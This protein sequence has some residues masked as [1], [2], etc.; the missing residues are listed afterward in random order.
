MCVSNPVLL[1]SIASFALETSADHSRAK[2]QVHVDERQ[3]TVNATHDV[4]R[5][6]GAWKMVVKKDGGKE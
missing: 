6:D 3:L 1:K 5:N 2:Y 4:F